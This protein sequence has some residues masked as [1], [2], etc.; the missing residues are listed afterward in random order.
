MRDVPETHLPA[1]DGVTVEGPTACRPY[2]IGDGVTVLPGY[3][4]VPGMGVLAAN[5]YLVDGPEPMLV[6]AGPCGAEDGFRRALSSVVDPAALRWLWLT[7]T[8]PDHV[9]SLEWLLEVAPDLRIVTTYLAVGKLSM[10]MQVPMDRLHWANPG[11]VVEANG[12]RLRA[13][14]PPSYDAPETVGF[15]DEGSS[16]LYSADS[17]GAVMQGP[18]TDAADIAAG[19]LTDGLV[20]WS[21]VDA[22]WITDVDRGR[23]ADNVTGVTSYGARRVLSAHL[24]PATGIT[25][26][27]VEAIHRVPEADPWVGPDQRGLEAILASVST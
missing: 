14:R 24:P 12:R 7:H 18:A 11:D 25:D 3:L 10:R 17:F 23:F 26:R 1:A 4:P 8:D 5:A 21:T 27:L 19:E 15:V 20:L 22:P 13:V 16:T 2:G 9:G 6:D